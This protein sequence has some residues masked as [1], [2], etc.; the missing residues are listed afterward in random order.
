MNLILTALAVVLTLFLG[1]ISF[2]QLLYLEALRLRTREQ[3]ALEFFKDTLED[4]LGLTTEQG[5]LTFSLIKHSTMVLLG[6]V[7]CGIASGGAALTWGSL[8]EAGASG[9]GIMVA[10]AYIV[11][12]WFYRKTSGRWLLALA[13]PLRWLALAVRPVTSFFAFLQTLATLNENPD[14]AKENGTSS[15]DLEALIEAGAD[16]GLIE[17]DDRKLIQS[18]VELGDKTVR[19]VMTPRASVVVAPQDTSIEDFRTLAVNSHFS[20]IP[21]FEESID[22]IAGFIHVRDILKL[23]SEE[24]DRHELKEFVRP[25]Q[26]VPETKPVADLF[27]EMQRHN[28]HMAIVVDEYGETAGI[29]TMEDVVEEVFGEIHDEYDSTADVKQEAEGT[30]LISGNVDLDRLDDLLG[31]RPDEETE[32]TTVGG[33]ITEW[34]GHVPAIGEVVEQEGIRIEVTAGDDR[35][36][37]QVRVSR[38]A[39]SEREA[40]GRNGNKHR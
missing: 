29:A 14:E 15:E 32:S 5:A 26:F 35:H 4:R 33:L 36:V 1:L 10:G 3:A 31:F 13:A 37:E 39:A 8:V 34:L 30:Y 18:V 22:Q 17:E 9:L 24:R 12:Q 6:L 40:G 28:V 38:D 19:E 27:R 7:F 21:V 2:V 16:E 11:P 23:E 20:R 25:T